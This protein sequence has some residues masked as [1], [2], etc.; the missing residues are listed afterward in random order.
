MIM[1]KQQGLN[2]I[3][4]VCTHACMQHENRRSPA[5]RKAIHLSKHLGIERTITSSHFRF[6][7]AY[8]KYHTYIHIG[9]SSHF[10]CSK[11]WFRITRFLPPRAWDCETN[12]AG[13][14]TKAIHKLFGPPTC[15]LDLPLGL[16]HGI[17]YDPI[18]FFLVNVGNEIQW[19]HMQLRPY[20]LEK[21]TFNIDKR[22]IQAY[23]TTTWF[24]AG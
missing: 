2:I 3:S 13:N 21:I 24:L 11:K 18:I 23:K 4:F 5:H 20:A 6:H 9:Y 14:R 22:V 15:Q 1:R 7:N 10:S 16:N 8:N 17:R 12:P 19:R